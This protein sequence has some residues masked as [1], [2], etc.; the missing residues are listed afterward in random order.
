M[1]LAPTAA[2]VPPFSFLLD[3]LPATPAQVA[4]HL[5]VSLRTLARWR[6]A[7]QAPR[8]VMLALFFESR[9]GASAV[10]AHAVNDARIAYG[11]AGSL[12]RENA[13]LR[14]RIARLDRLGGFGSANGP[15]WG[16]APALKDADSH[17]AF[18]Q[19]GADR[20]VHA[21]RRHNLADQEQ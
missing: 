18:A 14:A 17:H 5:G 11:L 19:V 7:D 6:A 13:T 16:S 9:W 4:R 3:D 15:L 20:R 2:N 10:N 12:E 21:G 1:F 8:A